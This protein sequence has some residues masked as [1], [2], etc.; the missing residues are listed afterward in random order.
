MIEINAPLM[1]VQFRPAGAKAIVDQLTIGQRLELEPEPTNQYDANAVKVIEPES[2]E[3]IGYVAKVS[4]Y[5][6]AQHLANGG[7]YACEVLS[8]L[9]TRK[10]DLGIRLF[11]SDDAEAPLSFGEDEED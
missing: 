7:A 6:T 5:E 4:N 2:G 10:P 3:F 11:E 8:F 9:G 1:G